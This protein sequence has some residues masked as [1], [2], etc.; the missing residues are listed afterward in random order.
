MT[1]TVANDPTI[2]VLIGSIV[3]LLSGL[4]QFARAYIA[5]RG[6][7]YPRWSREWWMDRLDVIG[8]AALTLGS[9]AVLVGA[10]MDFFGTQYC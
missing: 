10:W 2:W 7:T 1:C 8:W 3:L 4:V 6:A 5:A 9:I